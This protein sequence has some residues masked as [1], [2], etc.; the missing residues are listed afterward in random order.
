MLTNK[1]TAKEVEEIMR[2][3]SSLLDTSIRKVMETC[4]QDEF[5]AYRRVVGRIMG[6]IYLD[7]MQPIHLKFPD[8]EPPELRRGPA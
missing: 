2:Q 7:V 8:L 4:P 6:G 5:E 1:E 3:C